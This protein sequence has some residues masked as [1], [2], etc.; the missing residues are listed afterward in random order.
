MPATRQLSEDTVSL[1]GRHYRVP[2]RIGKIIANILNHHETITRFKG[3]S[4]QIHFTDETARLH[5]VDVPV[6][7]G[8]VVNGHLE[9]ST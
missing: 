1:N 7:D 4:L 9:K 8:I 3:G 5:V 2:Q 6:C